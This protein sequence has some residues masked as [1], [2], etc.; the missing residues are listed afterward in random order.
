MPDLNPTIVGRLLNTGL[1]FSGTDAWVDAMPHTDST[2]G[3]ASADDS[4]REECIVSI[5]GYAG[6]TVTTSDV[7]CLIMSFDSSGISEAPASATL[8]IF[9]H[10]NQVTGQPTSHATDGILGLKVTDMASTTSLATSDWGDID[11]SGAGPVLYTDTLTTWNIVGDA[12]EHNIFTLNSTALTDMA[13]ND[14]F[15]IAIFHKFFYDHYDSNPPFAHGNNSP[16]GDDNFSVT[17]GAYF[18]SDAD[19]KPVLS[20]VATDTDPSIT[21]KVLSGNLTIKS[22][23]LTIK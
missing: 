12:T 13:N 15:Q 1:D 19:Y 21:L 14:T 6:A 11:L 20:Y 9:G 3:Q 10:T 8:K 16:D 5:F 22:G 17:A 2:A 4:K 18:L 7:R 23:K